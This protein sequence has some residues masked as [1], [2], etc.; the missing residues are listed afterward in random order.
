[1]FCPVKAIPDPHTK[2]DKILVS[3]PLSIEELIN[4]MRTRFGIDATIISSGEVVIYN[5]F[6][7]KKAHANR[8]GRMIEDIYRE[9]TKIPIPMGRTYLALELAGNC[10]DDDIDFVIPTIKYK[11][12]HQDD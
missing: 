5:H 8:R 9:N 10:V 6:H 4:E 2:F 7:P 12:I 3:G 1:M 11:F